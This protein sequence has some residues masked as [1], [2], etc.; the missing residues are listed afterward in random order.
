[1]LLTAIGA[2]GLFTA[3]AA[4]LRGSRRRAAGTP[5]PAN[6]PLPPAEA[7]A[8]ISAAPP[9]ES[10]TTIRPKRLGF[11][12]V[13]VIGCTAALIALQTTAPQTAALLF[14]AVIVGSLGLGVWQ[15]RAKLAAGMAAVRAELNATNRSV[16][17]ILAPVGA[18]LLRWRVPFS[19]VMTIGAVG[20]M[21]LS[22]S[23]FQAARLGVLRLEQPALL[24]TA[25]AALLWGA[26][27]LRGRLPGST[28]AAL[29][30]G[31][32]PGR[33]N[34][35]ITGAGVALL[36]VLA[37]MNGNLLHL[38]I[39][40]VVSS[41]VQIVLLVIGLALTSRGLGAHQRITAA[42]GD[43]TARNRMTP[44]L[45]LAILALA[46]SLRYWQLG[47]AVHYL[48][49]EMNTIPEVLSFKPA[50]NPVKLLTQMNGISPFPWVFAYGQWAGTQFLGNTLEGIRLASAVTG[51][52]TVLALYLLARTLFDSTAAVMAA[53]L[54]ATFPPHIHFSRLALLN[55]ADPLVGTLGLA[56]LGRGLV[57]QRR[58]D[59]ALGGAFLGLTQYFYN[60]GRMFYIPLAA[61]WVVLLIFLNRPSTGKPSDSAPSPF[62]TRLR[63]AA[64]IHWPG[65]RL[66]LLALVIAIAPIYYTALAKGYPLVG[67]MEA[68]GLSGDY[69]RDLM[70][71]G[72][73][74]EYLH[75]L[76]WAFR[77]YVQN[78]DDSIYY[79]GDTPLVLTALVPVFLIGL[80]YC[81]YHR[82]KPGPLLLALWV[83]A[84]G[85]GNSI[86]VMNAAS[87]R[88]VIV[89]PALPLLVAVGIR[90]TLPLFWPLRFPVFAF[91][92]Q[93]SL[94][95]WLRYR[96]PPRDVARHLRRLALALAAA[97]AIVQ[98]V[99]YFGVH[100]PYYNGQ[101]RLHHDFP[102]GYDAVFRSLDFPEATQIHIISGNPFSQMDAQG[103]MDFL[104]GDRREFSTLTIS[105]FDQF[106]ID[107]LNC[108][109][110]H[111]FFIQLNDMRSLSLLRRNFYLRPP[112]YSPDRDIIPNER[113]LVLYYAPYIPG[114]EEKYH[115]KCNNVSGK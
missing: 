57:H 48:V 54:L 87:T 60:G 115:R 74:G 56:F 70:N 84:G 28:P 86:M 78:P 5:A 71:E 26:L 44:L 83:V 52:F 77:F 35:M 55:I 50:Y 91:R 73:Y 21:A 68:S 16:T 79:G 15:S 64:R 98:A 61:V 46:F 109:L 75:R 99:Y 47:T 72:R 82:R 67:R 42:I 45:L 9:Q 31:L 33:I 69:W 51:T 53:L 85:L 29:S 104:K 107:T 88:F 112:E 97:A 100:L 65:L 101:L 59:Y 19:A 24:M 92:I 111:A 66:A 76:G 14:I 103:L 2:G 93:V 62:F 22:A 106:Y 20:L 1:M 63:D 43:H 7:A 89:F 110:N 39:F 102:D 105:D 114:S 41:H 40:Q 11:Y 96:W 37:E 36:A 58:V 6:V 34:W 8:V 18:W 30:A 49:D 80:A 23:D 95:R 38:E 3:L 32:Q 4:R 12:L 94:R 17:R 90:Y 25:G 13:L 81:L 27:R 113:E 10:A 108:G